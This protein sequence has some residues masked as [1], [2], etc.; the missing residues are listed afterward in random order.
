L[1]YNLQSAFK[2]SEKSAHIQILRRK[3]SEDGFSLNGNTVEKG[4]SG[5][6][7]LSR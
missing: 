7:N 4:G 5:N 1:T 6:C 3:L 2:Y